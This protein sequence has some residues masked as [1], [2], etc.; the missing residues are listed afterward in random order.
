MQQHIF[1]TNFVLFCGW[2]KLKK[3]NIIQLKNQLKNFQPE[4]KS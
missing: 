4:A 1:S 2:A 3:I